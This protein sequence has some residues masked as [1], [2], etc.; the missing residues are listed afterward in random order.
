MGWPQPLSYAGEF[1]QTVL[2][3]SCGT[4]NEFLTHMFFFYPSSRTTWYASHL[5]LRVH[6]L[7]LDFTTALMEVTSSLED[8]QIIHFLL[9]HTLVHLESSKPRNILRYEGST[10]RNTKTS[11]NDGG[12]NTT[13]ALPGTQI[14]L[15]DASWDANK[16]AGWGAVYYNHMG[17]IT[18]VRYGAM[19]ADNPFR[20]EAFALLRYWNTASDQKD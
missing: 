10:E 6:N 16:K 14:V 17:N 8:T 5:A 2:C 12:T 9:Q 20:A 1:E 11:S 13:D 18:R 19:G 15:L 4:E 3:V 7:P